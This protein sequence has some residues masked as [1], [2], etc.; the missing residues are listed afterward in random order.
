MKRR[1]R[2]GNEVIEVQ[3]CVSPDGVTLDQPKEGNWGIHRGASQIHLTQDHR[4]ENVWIFRDGS[5]FWISHRGRIWRVEELPPTPTSQES[6][7]VHSPEIRSP[8]TGKVRKVYVQKGDVVEKED[9]LVTVE[10]MKMEYHLT[11]PTSAVVEEVRVKEGDL[12]DLGQV[13]LRLSLPSLDV[14]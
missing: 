14:V 2:I 1:F 11:A 5:V 4:H 13:L 8:L 10:A 6:Q 3:G 9:V 7:E 12:V